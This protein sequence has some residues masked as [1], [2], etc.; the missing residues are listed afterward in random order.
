MK[1]R[2]AEVGSAEAKAARRFLAW[3]R[4]RAGFELAREFEAKGDAARAALCRAIADAAAA[5]A[6]P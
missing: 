1:K 4:V 5:P 3:L 6:A 2:A